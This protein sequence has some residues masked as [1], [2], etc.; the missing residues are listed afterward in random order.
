MRPLAWTFVLLAVLRLAEAVFFLLFILAPGTNPILQGLAVA[1]VVLLGVDVILAVFLLVVAVGLFLGSRTVFNFVL[2]SMRGPGFLLLAL[3][4]FS[5][6]LLNVVIVALS[7]VNLLL[8][9][10]LLSQITSPATRQAVAAMEYEA[11]S[12]DATQAVLR[13]R[14]RLEPLHSEPTSEMEIELVDPTGWL[15]PDCDGYNAEGTTRCGAC[16][17]D[18]PSSN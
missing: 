9:I 18:R 8:V 16:R 13:Q 11:P 14:G 10:L 5:L 1:S 4:L 7:I 12:L 3:S 6:V 17:N 2:G 15:C